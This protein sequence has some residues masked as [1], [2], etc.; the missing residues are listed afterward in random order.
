M[1]LKRPEHEKN[2]KDSL[3]NANFI[4]DHFFVACFRSL[5][6]SGQ[7]SSQGDAFNPKTTKKKKK[8]PATN[9]EKKKAEKRLRQKRIRK[10]SFSLQFFLQN[11]YK[12]TEFNFPMMSSSE[13]RERPSPNSE[14]DPP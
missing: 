8:N 6:F 13:P 4:G 10:R 9:K 2:M 7:R 5:E 14:E 1:E 11:L 3:D 12:V